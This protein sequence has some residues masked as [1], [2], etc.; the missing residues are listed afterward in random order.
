MKTLLVC[1]ATRPAVAQLAKMTPLS[2]VHVCG[3]SLLEYWLEHLVSLGATEVDILA[4]D[5][6]EQ[7]RALVGDGARWGLKVTVLAEK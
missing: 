6:P 7:V 5:R 4:V 2:N 3:K 1:P